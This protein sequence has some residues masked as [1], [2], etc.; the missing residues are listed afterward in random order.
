MSEI[1]RAIEAILF[2]ADEPLPTTDLA[3]LLEAPA[4]DINDELDQLR[5]TYEER[6]SGIVLREVAGG[7]RLATHPSAAEFLER[8]VA[9]HRSARLTQAA[10]ETLAIVAYRQPISRAQ[11]AE[12]R[13]VSSEG[14]LKTLVV[15]ELIEE[16][17][18]D[19]GPGLAI[20]YGTTPRLLERL[21]LK[22]LDDLPALPEFMPDAKAVERMESGLG[23]SV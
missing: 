23:P 20:L 11:I 18:R 19:A 16:V 9:E 17:G 2:L 15:R 7:W 10:L 5:R 6:N 1:R 14:V 8:F 3:V 13:G 21:G 22:S 12:I 4:S